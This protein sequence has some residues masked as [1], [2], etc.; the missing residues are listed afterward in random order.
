MLLTTYTMARYIPICY[1]YY[2]EKSY[3]KLIAMYP[4]QW[5]QQPFLTRIMIWIA[6]RRDSRKLKR[7]ETRCITSLIYENIIGRWLFCVININ[8][9]PWQQAMVTVSFS[10]VGKCVGNSVLTRSLSIH[11]KKIPT[12]KYGIRKVSTLSINT[13][14]IPTQKYGKCHKESKHP[15]MEKYF[16]M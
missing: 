14:K 5:W 10:L 1:Y 16:F 4:L 6:W 2:G 7:H 15:L 12:Q 9:L 13:N 8:V 11:T 3:V